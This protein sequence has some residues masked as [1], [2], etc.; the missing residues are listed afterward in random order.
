MIGGI[1]SPSQLSDKPIRNSPRKEV[2]MSLNNSKGDLADKF[3]EQLNQSPE[4]V[5]YLFKLLLDELTSSIRCDH[6]STNT[7]DYRFKAEYVFCQLSLKPR[8]GCVKVELRIDDIQ[9]SS[10]RDLLVVDEGKRDP[11]SRW[12]SFYVSRGSQLKDAINLITSAFLC[13]AK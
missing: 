5:Q 2:V 3:S 4:T 12:V 9:V 8:K 13:F 10:T 1:I 11:G 6:Y 7:P